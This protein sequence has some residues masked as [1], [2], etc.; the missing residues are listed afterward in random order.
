MS[1]NRAPLC[2][3]WVLGGI[4]YGAMTFLEAAELVL[5]TAKKPLTIREITGMALRR[6][7]IETRGKTPEATMSAALYRMPDDGRSGENSPR[8]AT[9]YQRATDALPQPAGSGSPSH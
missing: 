1:S 2:S 7:L 8:G 3:N 6:G 9:E 4:R 5:R